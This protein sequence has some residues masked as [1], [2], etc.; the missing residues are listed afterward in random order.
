M[1]TLDLPRKYRPTSLKEYYGN[2]HVKEVILN[3][4]GSDQN[5]PQAILISG[6]SG[7]GKTTLARLIAKEYSCTNRDTTQGACCTCPACQDMDKFIKTG[8]TSLL[9]NVQEIDIAENSRKNDIDSILEEMLLPTF[10]NE[11]KIYIFDEVHNSSP[12]LQNRLLKIVEE[13]PENILM[14]FCTTNPE[15]LLDT[16]KNRCRITFEIER[17]SYRELVALLKTIC[18]AEKWDVTK[19]GLDL[20]I[21]YSDS[22]VRTC[23]NNIQQVGVEHG[24]ITE[25]TV[26][27]MFKVLPTNYYFDL[28]GA[29]QKGNTLQYISTLYNI[30]NIVSLDKFYAELKNFVK[31]GIYTIN[32]LVSENLTA[33]QVKVYKGFFEKFSL[34]ELSTLMTRLLTLDT[35]NLELELMMLGYTGLK[36][37]E[38]VEKTEATPIIANADVEQEVSEE[39]E[40]MKEKYLEEKKKQE[41]EDLQKACAPSPSINTDFLARLGATVVK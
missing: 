17:P 29:L 8:D 34:D 15:K 14:I 16:L 24:A 40:H 39:N 9:V 32:G 1:Q 25:D 3:Q 7:C 4:L 6:P 19:G 35:M 31:R 41:A 18:A 30:K 12:A 11:W 22:V 27:Q 21:E 2:S 26:S 20:I 13:P 33:D 5:R 10:D 23:L 37:K 36:S 28:L 38:I